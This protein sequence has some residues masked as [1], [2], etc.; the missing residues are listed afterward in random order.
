[1]T[2]WSGI[3]GPPIIISVLERGDLAASRPCGFTPGKRVP[4]NHWIGGWV[5]PRAGL[6]TM[7]ERKI[8]FL[9]RESNPRRLSR[10]CNLVHV[11]RTI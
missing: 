6:D 1:V 9:C 3:I 8:S 10:L 4:G 5:G 2:G 7:E 11:N